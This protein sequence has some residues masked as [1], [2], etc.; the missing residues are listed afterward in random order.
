MASIS[1]IEQLRDFLENDLILFLLDEHTPTSEHMP[2]NT[3]I[4][5]S[6]PQLTEKEMDDFNSAF[7]GLN[8]DDNENQQ[9][10]VNNDDM[11]DAVKQ[12]SKESR[13]FAKPVSHKDITEAMQKAVPLN[14]Q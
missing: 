13:N 8:H 3:L 10:E 14:T 5:N 9:T 6:S 4:D 2:T 11:D 1:E 12:P 7:E